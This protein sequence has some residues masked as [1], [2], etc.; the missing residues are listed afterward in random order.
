[1]P[2]KRRMAALAAGVT[3]VAVVSA[4]AWAV[5]ARDDVELT[6]TA[7]FTGARQ[8][9][10]T[11]PSESVSPA[12]LNTSAS[13]TNATATAE[14]ATPQSATPESA[15]PMPA[16]PENTAGSQSTGDA[17]GAPTPTA[18]PSVSPGTAGPSSITGPVDAA[19]SERKSASKTVKTGK[20]KKTGEAKTATTPKVRV[21]SSGT[22]GASFYAEGQMTASGE[23]FN[24][25][26]MT[27]AHKSLPMGS[28]VRV[29]NPANGESVTVRINDRGPYVGG[30]CL[31]L[32]RAAFGAIGDIGAGVMRVKYEVLGS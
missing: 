13:G 9:S 28:R 4:T 1:M 10:E 6:T 21:I 22:C 19:T 16:T 12:P 3:V 5:S 11:T 27:A 18:K 2:G 32:S 31:D 30:R 8:P 14:K 26:A 20:A 24:P 23:R 29:T 25:N 15:A 17:S 7:A